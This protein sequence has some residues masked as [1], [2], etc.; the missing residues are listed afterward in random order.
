MPE[1]PERGD[2]AYVDAHDPNLCRTGYLPSPVCKAEEAAVKRRRDSFK[3]KRDRTGYKSFTGVALSGGGIRSA[4]FGLGAL[5]G[6]QAFSGLE[7]IDYLSTVSGGGY[8]GCSLTAA[9]QSSK[10]QFPFT[11]PKAGDFSDTDSVRHVRDFSNYLI[12]HGAL[13]IVTALGIIGRGLVANALILAPILLFF[14]WLT[15]ASHPT[16]ASLDQPRFL[17]W[18]LADALAAQGIATSTPLWGLH[19]FWFTAIVA[20]L[21]LIFLIFWAFAKSIS[22]SHFWQAAFTA[23]RRTVE[24]AELR[25][26]LATF[27]KILFFVT[28]ITLVFE[29]QPFILRSMV[30]A[31]ALGSPSYRSVCTVWTLSGDCIGALLHGWFVYLTPILAPIGAA[32]A[33]FTKYFGDIVALSKKAT[34]WAPWLKKI[35]AMAAL[36]FAAIV[37]PS[38]LWLL[39]LLLSF[40]GLDQPSIPWLYLVAAAIMGSAATLIDPNATSLYRLYR[41]RLAKAFLFN[42]NPA[43]RDEKYG[44]LQAYE[45]KLHQIDTNLCPYPIVNAALNIEGSQYANKRGRNADFF[46]FTPEYTGSE[47][48]GYV[49]TRN[50]EQEEAALDLG[51]AMAISAAALSPNMGAE[52]IKPL[53]FTLTV[54]N[55][56]LGYW[57]R[58]PRYV[59]GRR[60]WISRLFDVRS[61]LLFKEMFSWITEKSATVYLTDGGHIENLG[62]YSL[63]KRRCEVIFVVDAEADPNLGFG[64]FL[65]LERYARIDLGVTID[66]P[67]PAIRYRS[68][69]VN[70]AFVKAAADGSDIPSAP[71]PHWAAGE[72]QYGPDANGVA[73]TGV[74]IYV[75]ASLSGDESD[76]ILDYKRLNPSFP[77][78]TTGDQFFGEE[79]LEAYRALGFHIMKGA[80]LQDLLKPDSAFPVARR[81]GENEDQARRRVRATVCAGLGVAGAQPKH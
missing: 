46:V 10:G 8:I 44:D 7:G 28:L 68:L 9:T 73:Q 76:Y 4:S 71:G 60:T 2:H 67:W 12:P 52:T 51:S 36:W 13:D 66:L 72:I 3:N 45:P 53:A 14:A 18:N 41:D 55:I 40:A 37:I 78:E 63:L 16:A 6:L 43:L 27:S 34:G 74:L 61:F 42:T 64:S 25:G 31:R 17:G 80:I 15:L 75:K 81:D 50:I 54:L 19:G 59:T 69:A 11:S 26:G 47:A 48:T 70:A 77:H 23:R 1:E 5:Q 58:N 79:Q 21:N 22:T 56:R 57:L 29:T 38:F 30:A 65:I 39:Y 24:S 35:A 49:G 20:A 32:F 33:L 62:L